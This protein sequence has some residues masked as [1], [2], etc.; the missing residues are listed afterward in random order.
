MFK[1][2]YLL[3][4]F[5]VIFPIY[6]SIIIVDVLIE[7]IFAMFLNL[8]KYYTYCYLVHICISLFIKFSKKYFLIIHIFI[9]YHPN[10]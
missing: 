9:I 1:T 4:K 8:I 5:I 6:P 3:V 10:N 7:V 2:F